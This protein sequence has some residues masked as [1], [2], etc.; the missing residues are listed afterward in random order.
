[1][2]PPIADASAMAAVGN[3][4]LRDLFLALPALPI[5]S[6]GSIDFEAA[7]PQILMR[8]AVIAETAIQ[9]AHRGQAAVGLPFCPCR[10]V[11]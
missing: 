10:P 6:A 5:T 9:M 11:D 7:D 3:L 4:P 8:I 1:M 2:A